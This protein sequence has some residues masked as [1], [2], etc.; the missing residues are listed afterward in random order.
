MEIY[1]NTL[2]G[3]WKLDENGEP[4]YL[5]EKGCFIGL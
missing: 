1:Q 5:F 4:Y 2:V 3:Q